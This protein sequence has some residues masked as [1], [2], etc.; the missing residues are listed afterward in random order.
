[1]SSGPEN[2]FI[3]SVHK[4]LPP[5]LYHMKNHN[6]YVS[7][8]ADVWYD[9]PRTDMW[10]EYKFIVVP[11]RETTVI[12]LVGGK[13]PLLTPLQQKWLADRHDNGRTVMVI[14]GCAAGGVVFPGRSWEQP[15]DAAAFVRRLQSRRDLADMIKAITHG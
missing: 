10:A 8:P 1:M 2:T 9:G 11:K 4:F 3:R 6:Q 15:I 13:N 7:G 12:D 5:G 14:V